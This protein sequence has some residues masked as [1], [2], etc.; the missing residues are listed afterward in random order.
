MKTDIAQEIK[1][2]IGHKPPT[3][4]FPNDW[5]IVTTDPN[6]QKDFFVEDTA[7]WTKNGDVDCLG[8]FGTLMPLAK[9]LITMPEIK[10][11]RI[12]QY[13]KIVSNLKILG[14]RHAIGHN[15]YCIN[16]EDLSRYNFD[17]I[18][19]PTNNSNFLLSSFH[20]LNIVDQNLENRTILY[21]YTKAHYIEDLL[22]FLSDAIIC[23]VI[24]PDDVF[25]ILNSKN[26]L[27]AAIGIGVFP[28]NVFIK[29]LEQTEKVAIYYY[30]NSW[31]KR[32]DTYQYRN[33]GFCIEILT[34]Y[35]IIK[36]LKNL[37]IDPYQV[38]GF[39]TVIDKDRNYDIGRKEI[40]VK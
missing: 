28:K 29:I 21:H 22:R 27:I 34:S 3:F 1:V 9:K 33:F 23:K 24:F 26:M 11:I 31:I 40:A 16:Q 30:N 20:H 13:R 25:N 18:T 7:I 39:L 37:N 32:N 12:A 10:T 2:I 6:N 14:Y 15:F 5:H 4:Q 38:S 8:E 17:K 36:E 19:K 35:L